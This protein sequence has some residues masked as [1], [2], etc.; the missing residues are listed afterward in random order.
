MTCSEFPVSVSFPHRI[1]FTCDAFGAGGAGWLPLVAEGGKV[2]VYLEGQVAA[3]TPALTGKI[4][5]CLAQ[6]PAL[7]MCGLHIH[8]GGEPCKA[9]D[10]LVRA[11]WQGIHDA[12]LDRHSFVIAVGGGAF[13]DAVGYAAATAHRGVRLLRFPTTTLAQ[14][15]SAVGVKCAI[16]AFGKK[17]WLGTFAVPWGVVI[18]FEFLSTLDEATCRDGLIE[19]VKV[20]LVKDPEF[21][22]WIEEHTD[23]LA[24][25]DATA[26]AECIERSAIL[27][28]RH[29]A[30]SGDPFELGSSR[31]L[32]FGHWAAHHLEAA[33][34]G[35]LSH[36]QAVALG[37]QL[38]TLYSVQ[39]GLAPALLAERVFALIARLG[40]PKW[41]PA[42][43]RR[44]ANGAFSLLDGLESFREH[45]GGQLT[46][47][48]LSDI[49]QGTDCH[50]IDHSLMARCIAELQP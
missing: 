1:V 36:A 39:S 5:A 43:T 45:L 49:G 19:A 42:M 3:A 10:S 15:D 11:V 6:Q 4:R 22:C 38:D 35:A 44:H 9:D 12:R 29:I 28:A 27:H 21:F 33:T 25:R 41:H 37:I 18:D 26:L 31:P 34:E 32:D 17:N 2:L 14:A 13:L 47:L 48:L 23:A 46:I 50:E 24:A 7:D 16:N 30:E 20:A 8:A 40:L